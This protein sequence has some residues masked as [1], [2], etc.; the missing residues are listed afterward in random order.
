[1]KS[2]TGIGRGSAARAGWEV[3]VQASSVNRKSLEVSFSLPREWQMIEPQLTGIVRERFARGRVHVSVDVHSPAASGPR[4]DDA[5][6][7]AMLDRLADLAARRNV[8][9]A[10][11]PEL[12]FQIATASVGESSILVS[13]EAVALVS[14]AL[15]PALDGLA[16]TRAREGANLAADLRSRLEIMR[17][18]AESI[19]ALAPATV[20]KYRETLLERLRKAGL[21][22]DVSD[23]RVLK[24]IALFAERID[25]AEELTRLRSHL[26]HFES[27]IGAEEPSGRKAEFI[28]QEIGREVHTI[29]S[30]ANDIE[31]ARLVIGLKNEFERVR[32]QIQNVE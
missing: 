7:G 28:L 14:E 16:E 27:L 4:W 26:E 21:E 6:V 5:A 20:D 31:I 8:A 15:K 1:M 17:S 2:M 12:L 29:G 19:A 24:E 23:E 10:V 11:T 32:E 18:A 3:V 25:I 13:D 30:K 9:F 22:L